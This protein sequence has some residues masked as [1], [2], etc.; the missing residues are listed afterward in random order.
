V[1]HATPEGNRARDCFRSHRQIWESYT[2]AEPFL[3]LEDDVGFMDIPNFHSDVEEALNALPEDWVVLFLGGLPISIRYEE[4]PG[5][6]IAVPSV[7]YGTQAYIVNPKRISDLMDIPLGE[8]E[9]DS[10]MRHSLQPGTRY[11][12]TKL[13]A[14]Q[15]DLEGYGRELRPKQQAMIDRYEMYFGD[16]LL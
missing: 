3:I 9:V 12:T 6:V 5:P 13:L 4:P 8:M 14:T 15:L 11:M 2:Q 10:A 16:H 1:T 7:M